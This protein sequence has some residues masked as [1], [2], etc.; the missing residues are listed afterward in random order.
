MKLINNN[1]IQIPTEARQFS[2]GDGLYRNMMTDVS[3]SSS[4]IR[5]CDNPRHLP[6]LIDMCAI[7]DR[8][9][10]GLSAYL[11]S[12]RALFPRFYF[13]SNDELVDILAR[14][15]MPTAVVPYLP[16]CFESI[17]TLKFSEN[18]MFYLLF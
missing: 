12:K 13:L 18:G 10:S 14:N 1:Y 3:K 5:V 7:F 11:E 8:V 4:V 15:T 9:L 6:L 17:H 16:K 2:Q